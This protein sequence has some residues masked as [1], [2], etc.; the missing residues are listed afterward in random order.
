M[1]KFNGIKYKETVKDIVVIDVCQYCSKKFLNKKSYRNHILGGYCF[2]CDI[3][4]GKS[5]DIGIP[6]EWLEGGSNE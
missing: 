2:N 5:V 6:L 4:T 1:P 3:K